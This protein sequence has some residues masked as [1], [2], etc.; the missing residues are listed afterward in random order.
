LFLAVGVRVSGKRL[1]RKSTGT[2][3]R[4]AMKQPNR[5]LLIALLGLIVVL[6]VAMLISLSTKIQE[7]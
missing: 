5:F 3:R 2:F 4:S 7:Q 6:G 1:M